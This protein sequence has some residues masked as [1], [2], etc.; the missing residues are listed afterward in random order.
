[1]V[2]TL[3]PIQSRHERRFTEEFYGE[4]ESSRRKGGLGG[5]VNLAVALQRA[6]LKMR[7]DGQIQAPYQWAGFVLMG[8]WEMGL[9]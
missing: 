4:L 5:M 8:A 1:V 7:D 9:R 2:G 6:A 3:W